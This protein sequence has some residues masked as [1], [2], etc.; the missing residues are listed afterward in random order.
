MRKSAQ[1]AGT[2]WHAVSM[3]LALAIVLL[4]ALAAT[5]SAQAQTYNQLYS[6]TG[7]SDGGYPV[8]GSLV[9]DSSG[10]LYGVTS[11][12]GDDYCGVLFEVPYPYDGTETVLH[13]FNCGSDGG[14]PYGGVALGPEGVLYGTAYYYGTDYYGTAWS[15]SLGTSTFTVLYNFTGTT[16]AYPFGGVTLGP[17]HMLYGTT[18]YGGAN[19]YGTVYQVNP[20]TKTEK[21]LHSFD[22]S[23]GAYPYEGLVFT[24]DNAH[25][26]IVYG[27]TYYG[28]SSGYGTVFRVDVN[29]NN[30]KSLYSW[31][32]SDGGFPFCAVLRG[33]AGKM[34]GTT[35]DGG[36]DGCGT[37]W[38]LDGGNGKLTTLY[39]FTCGNDGGYPYGGVAKD[40]AGNLYGTAYYYG[41]NYYGTVWQLNTSNQL[42]PWVSFDY[43]DGAYPFAGPIIDSSGNLY[44]TAEEGGTNGAGVVYEVS[45][46]K[47]K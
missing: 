31:N 30:F 21:V 6:F 33:P 4:P 45:P 7:G 19:D 29:G 14:Y 39:N 44:G 20:K 23:D 28:G 12:G 16:G 9:E 17:G 1:H 22:Y 25:V 34:W 38:E 10:N 3:A 47:K 5:P 37:I 35:N 42:T 46:S 2:R 27:T 32:Y 24:Y 11:S 41:S 36:S 15:Y 8:Y 26:G 18:Y 43:S 40:S 13:S